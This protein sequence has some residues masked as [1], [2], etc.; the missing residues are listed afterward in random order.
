MLLSQFEENA[1]SKIDD[2]EDESVENIHRIG[3]GEV[4]EFHIEYSCPVDGSVFFHIR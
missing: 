2:G 1:R 3:L 4:V